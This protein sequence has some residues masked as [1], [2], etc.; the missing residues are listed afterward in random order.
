MIVIGMLCMVYAFT[1]T[2]TIKNIFSFYCITILVLQDPI[3]GL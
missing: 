1:A 3:P 2:F